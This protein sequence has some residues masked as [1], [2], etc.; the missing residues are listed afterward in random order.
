MST[1][2]KT[3]IITGGEMAALYLCMG[4]IPG[5]SMTTVNSHNHKDIAVNYILALAERIKNER[6]Q[7]LLNKQ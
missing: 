1:V 4:R 3:Y 6:I 7:A 5:V 2:I